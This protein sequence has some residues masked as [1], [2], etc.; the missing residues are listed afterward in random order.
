MPK[1]R[2]CEISSQR[3]TERPALRQERTSPLGDP[4]PEWNAP[5]FLRPCFPLARLRP[6]SPEVDHA[7]IGPT[8]GPALPPASYAATWANVGACLAKIGHVPPPLHRGRNYM[9]PSLGGSVAGTELPP[10]LRGAGDLVRRER[11]GACGV[12]VCDPAPHPFSRGPRVRAH[13]LCRLPADLSVGGWSR[14]RPNPASLSTAGFG[15]RAVCRRG[16]ARRVPPWWTAETSRGPHSCLRTGGGKC[17]LHASV[18]RPRSSPRRG[19]PPP[20]RQLLI[21]DRF[22]GSDHHRPCDRRCARCRRWSGDG[23]SPPTPPPTE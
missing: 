18:G 17:P 20:G 1:W 2:A 7:G 6:S 10:L 21:A 4:S 3:Q 15:R 14:R 16:D 9:T 22:L 8:L 23:R 19:C 13:R 5:R 11:H 12:G